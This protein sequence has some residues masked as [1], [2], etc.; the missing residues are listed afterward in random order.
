MKK[1]FLSILLCMTLVSVLALTGCSNSKSSVEG[2]DIT[3]GTGTE[4]EGGSADATDG[5]SGADSDENADEQDEET[6][7][8]DMENTMIQNSL[9]AEGN[10]YMVKKVLEKAQNG[11]DV[12]IAFIGGSITEGYN[13]GTTEI[14]AKLVYDYIASEYGTGDNVHY[15]NAGLSGTPSS[16]GLIRSDRDVFSYEPD[17][18]FIEFA[19]NDGT[20]TIDDTGL[21]SLVRKTLEQPNEAACILLFSVIKSGYTCQD[22][23]NIIGFNYDLPR[24][25]VKN[26]IWEYIEN[27]ELAWETWSND[28]SHP[29]EYG[30]KLYAQFIINYFKTIEGKEIDEAPSYPDKAVKGFDYSDM[31]MI[32]RSMNLDA[33]TLTQNG[34]FSEKGDLASF[35]EGWMH[36]AGAESNDSFTFTYTGKALFLVYKDTTNAAY[37][38]AE[39][40]IDGEY[41]LSL[42]ANTDDGWN[43]PVPELILRGNEPETH[44]VEIR[45]AED[46]L[47]KNFSILA[48]GVAP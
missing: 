13:A 45:M 26:A 32:D 19:V 40:Y 1:R 34:S 7:F 10:N 4:A 23:M 22:N 25:S 11:E 18:V 47:D 29:N 48:L 27:G 16:L 43:N 24:I 41:Q 12:T 36:E 20:S 6:V 21:E 8:T 2:D 33:I 42:Y 37:G 15:V 38:T 39:V 9:L 35:N 46:S 3:D 17:L 5:T 31:I 30:Q 44:T 14:Y 28:E